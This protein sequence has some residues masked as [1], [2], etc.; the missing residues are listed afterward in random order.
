M[1]SLAQILISMSEKCEILLSEV[2]MC[3]QAVMSCPMIRKFYELKTRSTTYMSFDIKDFH[4]SV[5]KN[6]DL[7]E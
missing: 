2:G 4:I 3:G 5:N 7:F 1:I 6:F